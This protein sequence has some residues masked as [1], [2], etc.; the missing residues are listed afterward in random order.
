MTE[1]RYA[2][3]ISV[4][5]TRDESLK[6][7]FW[8]IGKHSLLLCVPLEQTRLE[9]GGLIWQKGKWGKCG[10]NPLTVWSFFFLLFFKE[11]LKNRDLQQWKSSGETGVSDH[12]NLNYKCSPAKTA[13]ATTGLG[14]RESAQ[15]L[16][17]L[18]TLCTLDTALIPNH[19]I[20]TDFPIINHL[21]LMLR[22]TKYIEES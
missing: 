12:H 21:I 13:R 1:K 6:S 4:S 22:I 15:S 20:Q 17:I 19:F 5:A 11:T 8:L 10:N 3:H 7:I 16:G 18:P 14:H 2:I 9:Q